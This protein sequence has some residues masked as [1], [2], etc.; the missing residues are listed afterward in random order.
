MKFI[1]NILFYIICIVLIRLCLNGKF[2]IQNTIERAKD[3]STNV[4]N[5]GCEKDQVFSTISGK[6]ESNN[7]TIVE[8]DGKP[9]KFNQKLIT[10]QIVDLLPIF[11]YEE[12]KK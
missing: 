1:K 2:L 10:P 3:N 5:N 8:T 6:C 11:K 9:L 12:D 4:E 7:S